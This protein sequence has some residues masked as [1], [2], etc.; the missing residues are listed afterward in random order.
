MCHNESGRPTSGLAKSYRP[1]L[2]LFSSSFSFVLSFI[3]PVRGLY[4]V[5]TEGE[6]LSQ[7]IQPVLDTF[8]NRAVALTGCHSYG[9]ARPACEY[10][11]LVVAEETKPNISMKIG[12]TY[13]DVSF[14]TR[15]E[16]MNP[17]N[18]ELAIALSSLIPLRDSSW[19]LSTGASANKALMSANSKRS[20]ESR[21]SLALK[22]LGRA[23]EALRKNSVA[24]AD[25]W[26]S[27]SGYDFALASLY[28]SEVTPAPSHILKQMKTVSRKGEASFTEWSSAV[29]LERSSRRSC[30]RRLDGLLTIYDII[31]STVL[32][33][34]S[35]Q[36]IETRRSEY[37]VE[38]LQAKAKNLIDSMQS[39]DCFA[40]LGFDAILTLSA[41][42][43]LQSLRRSMEPDYGLIVTAVTKGKVQIISEEVIKSLGWT[44]SEKDVTRT[45]DL[46]RE[47]ISDQAKRI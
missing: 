35:S 39:V 6:S 12:E 13:C 27:S 31:S 5:K 7:A 43:E 42:L 3:S 25:F 47:G 22:G 2:G 17:S 28:A 29:G 30:E 1:I 24:D 10:D 11:L 41:L 9:I 44:R 21:L 18:P 26:L 40:Y 36:L 4:A 32:E 19:V 33:G 15:E 23:D 20:A 34:R 45:M 8:L 38:I 46:L 14:I 16:V 37:S